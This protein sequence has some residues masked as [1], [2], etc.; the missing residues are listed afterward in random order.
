M[1]C[2]GCENAVKRTLRQMTGVQ[3]VD[4]SHSGNLVRVTFDEGRLTPA[5]IRQAIE[6][7]GYT[8]AP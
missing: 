4:A 8:V 6:G 2:G 7:L 5:A 1:T 3:D